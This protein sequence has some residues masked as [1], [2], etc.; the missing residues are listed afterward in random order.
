[1]IVQ[2]ANR[3]EVAA[4]AADVAPAHVATT[5][6]NRGTPWRV[7]SDRGPEIQHFFHSNLEISRREY[8]HHDNLFLRGTVGKDPSSMSRSRS[9]SYQAMPEG[10]I[11]FATGDYTYDGSGNVWKIDTDRYHYDEANRLI[12]G[13]VKQYSAGSYEAV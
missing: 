6:V 10:P 13:T 4:L 1:M 9:Y 3:I 12:K 7:I 5:I 11:H 2:R 8:K